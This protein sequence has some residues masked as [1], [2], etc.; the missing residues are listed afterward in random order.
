MPLPPQRGEYTSPFFTT[1]LDEDHQIDIYFLPPHQ[2]PL[3]L[4][5][6]IVDKAGTLFQSGRFHEQ[7]GGNAVSLE[8][9]YRP[10]LGSRHRIIVNMH[11]DIEAPVRDTRLHIGVP[12]QGLQRS[13]GLMVLMGW[14]AL[15]G[16]AGLIGLIALAAQRRFRRQSQ[17]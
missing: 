8:R 9:H 7:V 6:K 14:A 2:T 15:V 5:W 1:E 17:P 11:D 4:D 10:K 16:G 3:D 13:Y 12:E